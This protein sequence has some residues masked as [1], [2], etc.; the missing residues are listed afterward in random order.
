MWHCWSKYL[1]CICIQDCLCCTFR[2]Q[3]L[4]NIEVFNQFK[5]LHSH[6]KSVFDM[7]VYDINSFEYDYVVELHVVCA[8]RSPLKG[9]SYSQGSRVCG[10]YIIHAHIWNKHDIIHIH[11]GIMWD[12]KCSIEYS[13]H[14]D[15]MWNIM[16]N[17]VSL[18]V[19]CYGYE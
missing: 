6:S 8:W 7:V 18:I 10:I 3:V 1:V 12:W 4:D 14:S 16:W 13:Q 19:H 9:T 2:T 11:D 5:T 15:L 17:N